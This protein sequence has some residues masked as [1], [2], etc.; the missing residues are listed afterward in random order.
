MASGYLWFGW[1]C[2]IMMDSKCSTPW[3]LFRELT[4]WMLMIFSHSPG[5][6]GSGGWPSQ[7][8]EPAILLGV[9]KG[10]KRMASCFFSD[11]H[12]L[13][14]YLTCMSWRQSIS[15]IYLAFTPTFHLTSDTFD[16]SGILSAIFSD[17]PSGI[18]QTGLKHAIV[19]SEWK[20]WANFQP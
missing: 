13:T 7:L 1:Y 17:I 18:L 6:A 8:I 19:R 5:G 4:K 20:G 14:F 15:E 11:P 16:L 3:D 12:Q 10:S 2:H 9:L